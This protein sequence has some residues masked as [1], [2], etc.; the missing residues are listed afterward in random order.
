MARDCTDSREFELIYVIANDGQGSKIVKYA[1]QNGI[2][3][4]TIFLG[5]GTV[6]NSILQLLELNETRKEI[7]LMAADNSTASI[8]MEE[9]NEKFDFRRPNHGI[10][11]STSVKSIV[12]ERDLGCIVNEESRGAENSMYN[13][14]FIIVDKGKAESAV[15][16]AT[17]AGSKGGTIINARGSGIHET[18]KLFSMEIEPE[19]EIVLIISEDKFTEAIVSSIREHLEMDKPGNG[20]IFVQNVNKTYGLSDR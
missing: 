11:F 2:R 1:K 9:L 4:G 7:V 5:K 3:G 10:A 17:A 16:A 13:V 18:S 6:K 8:V 19:K 14:I 15:E 20:I 12:G